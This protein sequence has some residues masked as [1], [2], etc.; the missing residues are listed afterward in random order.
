M[1]PQKGIHGIKSDR[2]LLG[3]NYL[4]WFFNIVSLHESYNFFILRIASF[5]RIKAEVIHNR[6]CEIKHNRVSEIRIN[7]IFNQRSQG[8]S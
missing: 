6:K 4:R 2:S 3:V 7:L 5:V 1:K 8:L